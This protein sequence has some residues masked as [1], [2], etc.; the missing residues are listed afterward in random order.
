MMN[1]KQNPNP[2]TIRE[3]N[4]DDMECSNCGNKPLLMCETDAVNSTPVIDGVKICDMWVP[5]DTFDYDDHHV[6]FVVVNAKGRW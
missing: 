4:Y 1:P 2:N 3:I 6:Q 5:S